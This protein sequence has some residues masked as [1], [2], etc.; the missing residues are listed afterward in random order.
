M[1]KIN[2]LMFRWRVVWYFIPYTI[3]L[4]MAHSLSRSSPVLFLFFIGVI[5]SIAGQALRI[6][7]A[8]FVEKVARKNIVSYHTL[9]LSG[10]YQYIRHPLYL[11][12]ILGMVGFSISAAAF[13]P[14][15][16]NI[17]VVISG[18]L[19]AIIIMTLILAH[20][21]P[22]LINLHGESYED[23]I[24]STPRLTPEF[25]RPDKNKTT[26]FSL[27]ASIK[28]ETHVTLFKIALYILLWNNIFF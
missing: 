20:E 15:P 10:P 27:T 17:I 23:F 1:K 16:D 2:E 8:G 9:I 11:G 18:A 12:N 19:S 3:S 25:K 24:K 13:L 26:F 21:E 5:I 6:W 7:G 22:Q 28:N 4:V 14:F